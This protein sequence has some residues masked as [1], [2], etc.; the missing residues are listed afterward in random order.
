MAI[1]AS[2]SKP[3]LST[4]AAAR[5]QGHVFYASMALVA[6]VVTIVGFGPT[7]YF[8]PFVTA[9][10]LPILTHVHGAVFTAWLLLFTLQI[11]LVSSNRTAVH[12]R[13]GP[14][15]AV[16]SV[17]MIVLGIMMIVVRARRGDSG[18]FDD[19]Q[20]LAAFEFGDM[21]I[22]ATL[23]GAALYQ[24]KHSEA[25]K[26]L[27]LLA[28]I[29]L[30]IA[31]LGRWPVMSGAWSLIPYA[32]LVLTGPVFDYLTLGHIHRAYMWSVPLVI[33]SVPLRIALGST[34]IWHRFFDVITA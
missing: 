31:A 7:Y 5:R 28:T 30:L 19:A 27:M 15:G 13:L 18:G 20:T 12:R 33:V 16:L 23:V 25:H 21:A 8:S 4:S 32:I 10:V 11:T 26:R 14:V 2:V 3:P 1:T 34:A 17:A 6:I 22:F 29:S 9:P 24:R